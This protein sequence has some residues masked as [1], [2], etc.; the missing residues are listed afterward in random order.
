V[1]RRST[2]PNGA[3]PSVAPLDAYAAALFFAGSRNT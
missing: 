1:A 3:W 2:L